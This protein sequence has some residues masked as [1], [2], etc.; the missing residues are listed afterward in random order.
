M[1]HNGSNHGK[2]SKQEQKG[3]ENAVGTLGQMLNQLLPKNAPKHPTK[4]R[5]SG[6]KLVYSRKKLEAIHKMIT[7]FYSLQEQNELTDR[8]RSCYCIWSMIRQRQEDSRRA[9]AVLDEFYPSGKILDLLSQFS[10]HAQMLDNT[11]SI[12]IARIKGYCNYLFYLEVQVK[13]LL[14]SYTPLPEAELPQQ[15]DVN[16]QAVADFLSSECS[17][18][19]TVQRLRSAKQTVQRL[20]QKESFTRQD[21]DAYLMLLENAEHLNQWSEQEL[22]SLQQLEAALQQQWSAISGNIQ[23]ANEI[24][25]LLQTYLPQSWF[26]SMNYELESCPLSTMELCQIK[27]YYEKQLCGV[28]EEILDRYAK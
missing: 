8:I 12:E 16:S 27:A 24:Y 19:P 15:F 22:L 11:S 2:P 17:T 7:I 9:K 10:N 20:L 26:D 4:N 14:E 28:R 5:D 3:F 23:K 13:K 6:N 1:N 18:F 21:Y 25:K